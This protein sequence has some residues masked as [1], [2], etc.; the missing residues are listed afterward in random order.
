MYLTVWLVYAAACLLALVCLGCV[1]ASWLRPV[2]AVLA[3][4]P[5]A[6]LC[7]LPTVVQVEPLWLA[8]QLA[9]LALQLVNGETAA[10]VAGSK[11][12]LP[13]VAL[14]CLPLLVYRFWRRGTAA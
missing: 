10:V 12:L 6:V 11:I 1:L 13:A 3:V 2:T 8:P 7:L 4:L 5:L 14:A 9:A